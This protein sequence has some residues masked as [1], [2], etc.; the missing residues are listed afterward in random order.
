MLLLPTPAEAYLSVPGFDFA[1]SRNSL[2]DET[3]VDG[4][5]SSMY[6]ADESWVTG[7]R[8]VSTLNGRFG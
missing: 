3:P 6:C 5:K 4:C 7:C 2:T 8:S 1:S